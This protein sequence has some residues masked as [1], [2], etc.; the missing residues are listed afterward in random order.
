VGK[1]FM[2]RVMTIIRNPTQKSLVHQSGSLN[3]I[4]ILKSIILIQS[5]L[6]MICRRN[7]YLAFVEEIL[8]R[9]RVVYEV[10]MTNV[11]IAMYIQAN[12]RKFLAKLE[13]ITDDESC[14]CVTHQCVV[15]I[16]SVWRSHKAKTYYYTTSGCC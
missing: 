12:L 11:A 1:F 13:R 16:Q 4:E 2:S 9:I 7:K 6:H 10:E 5:L 15:R 14:V 8:L 3:F